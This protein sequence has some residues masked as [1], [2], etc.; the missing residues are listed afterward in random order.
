MAPRAG[1]A[2][3][4][5]RPRSLRFDPGAWAAPVPLA[6]GDEHR[7]RLV[8]RRALYDHGTLVQSAESLAPLVRSQELRVS[9]QALRELGVE[10]GDE[11]RVRSGRGEIV[12]AAVGDR[13]V[14]AGVAFLQFNAAP[15]YDASASALV[16]WSV[17][18]VE[19][20]LEK[21]T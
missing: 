2:A 5:A 17:P 21:V 3:E 18:A 9:P 6:T 13:G 16:D 11:V 8:V 10:T 1:G 7:W 4:T 12:V 15:V 14:P 19:V 20:D